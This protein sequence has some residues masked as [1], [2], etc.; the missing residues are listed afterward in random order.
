[1]ICGIVLRQYRNVTDTGALQPTVYID[2][3]LAK[4]RC[5]LH[6]TRR[7]VNFCRAQVIGLC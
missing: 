4:K 5:I 2:R 6:I 1:M 7:L 3:R